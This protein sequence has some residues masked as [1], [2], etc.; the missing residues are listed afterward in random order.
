MQQL[1][2]LG[3]TTV[4][5]LRSDTEMQKYDSPI[6][7]IDGVEVRHIPVFKKEDY[8]PEAMAKCVQISLAPP[9]PNAERTASFA[10]DSNCM[11]VARRRYVPDAPFNAMY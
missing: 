7:T 10:G 5:D 11:Q 4:Y 1:K 9:Y 8:S 3:I 2:N 6:P